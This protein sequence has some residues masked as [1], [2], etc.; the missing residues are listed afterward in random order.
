MKSVLT[1]VF[2][3]EAAVATFGVK[4]HNPKYY[5]RHYF[6]FVMKRHNINRKQFWENYSYYSS[7]QEEMDNLLNDVLSDLS[8]KQAEQ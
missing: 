6:D 8:K 3:A 7:R 5:A 4:Q 2:L 1:D